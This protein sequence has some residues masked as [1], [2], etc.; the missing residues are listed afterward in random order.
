MKVRIKL[1]MPKFRVKLKHL[2]KKYKH[3]VEGINNESTD[4][5]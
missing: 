4:N 2:R 1:K 5:C 3:P